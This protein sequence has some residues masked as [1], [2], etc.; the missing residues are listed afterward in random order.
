MRVY[1]IRHGETAWNKNKLLQGRTDI[2]L[3]ENGKEAAVLTGKSLSEIHFD[4]CIVSPL[5]RAMETAEL[6]LKENRTETQDFTPD[7]WPSGT[8]SERGGIRFFT[9]RRLM[10]YC[11]GVWEGLCFQGPEKNLPLENYQDYW[12]DLKEEER[13]EGS[14]P[15]EEFFARVAD[16]LYELDARY[17]ESNANIL[18]VAHGAVSRGIRHELCGDAR[19][20]KNCEALVIEKRENGLVITGRVNERKKQ[21]E[22]FE[23]FC[24][25]RSVRK[26]TGEHIPEEK[27]ERILQA[28]LLAPSGRNRKPWEFILVKDREMLRKLSECRAAGA[29]ILA[30]ADAAIVVVG[31]TEITDVWTEDCSI[32]MAQMHLMA[33]TL[34]VGSCWVQGRL[35]QKADGTPADRIVKDLLAIPEKFA[36]EAILSLGIPENHPEAYDPG[37]LP[38]EKIHREKF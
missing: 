13:P 16:F 4:L 27:L 33:D 12:N 30:G 3:N 7:L 34:G 17:G 32:A 23:I 14:E 9:D 21:M 31:D 26:Y 6:I 11:F 35:R 18:V 19:S 29:V 36:L 1:Y 5:C 20:M 10:E 28:G 15:F 8:V 22:L 38:A 24:H 37:N 25:R 2:P